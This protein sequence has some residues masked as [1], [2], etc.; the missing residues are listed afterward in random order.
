MPITDLRSLSPEQ[1][2]DMTIDKCGFE[3]IS[4]PVAESVFDTDESIKNI[5]YKQC[6][7]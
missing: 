6:E 7:E 1:Q 4:E 3:V 5:Y 2:A